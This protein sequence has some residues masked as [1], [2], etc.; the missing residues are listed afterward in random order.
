MSERQTNVNKKFF[1]N[2]IIWKMNQDA[3]I[4]FETTSQWMEYLPPAS[5]GLGR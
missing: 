1:Y 4:S 2:P 3:H 5:E